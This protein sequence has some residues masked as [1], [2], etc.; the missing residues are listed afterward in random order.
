MRDLATGHIKMSQQ[1]HV[2]TP[3]DGLM[4]LYVTPKQ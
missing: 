4:T 3:L 2:V 1:I